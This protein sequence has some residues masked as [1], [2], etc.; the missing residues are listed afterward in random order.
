MRIKSVTIEGLHNCKSKTYEF[1]NVTYL[2]GQNGAGKTTVLNAIQL[3]LLGYIPGS[4]KNS[5]EAIFRHASENNMK[6][7]LLIEDESNQISVKRT[8]VGAGSTI[9]SD[10][11]ITPEGFDLDAIVKDLELPVFNFSDLLGLTSNKLKDWFIQL[12]PNSTGEIDWRAELSKAVEKIPNMDETI[13]DDMLA[14]ISE[15]NE[16]GVDQV[17][18]VNEYLKSEQSAIKAKINQLQQTVNTLIYYDDAPEMSTEEIQKEIDELLQIS[19]QISQYEAALA[20]YN[21]YKM[22]LDAARAKC[23]ASTIEEDEEYKALVSFFENNESVNFDAEI[24][25]LTNTIAAGNATIQA[26]IGIINSDSICPFTKT[27]CESIASQI[28][29]MI[30]ENANTKQTVD[31]A[32]VKLNELSGKK[33]SIENDINIKQRRKAEI[34][35]NY[36]ALAAITGSVEYEPLSPSE[37]TSAEIRQEITNLQSAMA[38]VEANKR[39][40]ELIETI[41]KDKFRAELEMEAYKIWAKLTDANGLQSKLAAEEFKAL[42]NEITLNI[43]LLTNNDIECAFNL[44]EKANSFSF[45]VIRAG[46]YIPFDLLS[47]GEKCIYTFGLL[48]TIVGRFNTPLKLI[49]VD[50]LLDHLDNDNGKM[51][52]QAINKIDKIQVIMAGVIDAPEEL[53]VI[54]VVK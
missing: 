29:T 6:V 9:V 52:L 14:V 18:R 32:T 45:G 10:V 41:T 1:G 40:N 34:E 48:M 7:E 33:R 54:K 43:A 2:F 13:I 38:K 44:S 49:M 50:D 16:T 15:F 37:K 17:R 53:S 19:Q 8:W 51:M 35:G 3:A 46:K 31:A 21:R 24:Q 26:N 4:G 36:R 12:L 5:K 42:S 47:S 23:P 27:R 28:K 30:E 22:T 11:Q 39:Y 25:Q 20:S